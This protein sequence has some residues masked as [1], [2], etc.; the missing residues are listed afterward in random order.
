MGRIAFGGSQDLSGLFA[1]LY[2]QYEDRLTTLAERSA[3][4]ADEAQAATDADTIDRW[5]QGELTDEEFLEYARQ[6]VEESGDDPEENTYWKKVLRDAE[7]SILS[8]QITDTAEDIIDKI[9]A[10]TATWSDLRNYYLR[11]RKKLRPSDPLYDQISDQIEQVDD[12]VA[13]WRDDRCRGQC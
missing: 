9:Q 4:R 7:K 6:R 11:E 13:Q 3:R 10:G 12:R 2:N 8:E 1:Q 5:Q